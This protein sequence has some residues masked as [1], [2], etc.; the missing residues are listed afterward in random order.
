MRAGSL[1]LLALAISCSAAPPEAPGEDPGELAALLASGDPLRR[2]E[3]AHRLVLRGR[4][5]R[6]AAADP[7]VLAL[8]DEDTASMGAE[9]ARIFEVVPGRYDRRLRDAY[10]ALRGGCLGREWRL[11]SAALARQ[12]FR[13]VEIY[14]PD[15]RTKSVRFVG[16]PAAYTNAA[17]D[18]HDLFFWVKSARAAPE[19]PW[20]AREVYVG[21]HVEFNAPYRA[22]SSTDRYPRGSVLALFFEVP[23]VRT[24]ALAF[25]VLEE[26]ELT[27]G[28]IRDKS[29]PSAP[30]GFHVNAGFAGGGAGAGG[31]RGVYYTAESGLD[32]LEGPGARLQ[33]AGFRPSETLGPLT[34][35]GS[36]FWG[37]GSVK[38]SDD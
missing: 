1:S 24:L 6:E 26:I 28:R 25:P 14:E 11:L 23:E 19:A 20:V 10:H 4:T 30:A 12:G 21:Y 35:R 29:S 33:W 13:L 31:G 9:L 38:P 15:E 18:R 36:S 5:V 7:R 8:L 16:R 17:G 27:Y 2:E 37:A 22:V 3:A 34:L 32:P